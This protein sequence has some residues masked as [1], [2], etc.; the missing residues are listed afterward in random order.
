MVM[1]LGAV[2]IPLSIAVL[3]LVHG[4]GVNA[5]AIALASAMSPIS[6][7]W[8][9]IGVGSPRSILLLDALPTLGFSL[10]SAVAISVLGLPLAAYSTGMLLAAVVPMVLSLWVMRAPLGVLKRYTFRRLCRI[11]A[12]QGSALQSRAISAVYIALPITLVGGAAPASLVVFS[13][14]E[15]L[16]RFV[17]SLLQAFPNAF[18]AWVGSSSPSDLRSR[19]KSVFTAN[20]AFGL[21]SGASYVF[22]APL[23]IKILFAGKIEVPTSVLAL[24]AGVIAIT[25]SSRVTGGIGLVAF[26]RL[27]ALRTSAAIG[28]A[29][30]IPAIFL[31]ASLDGADGA[32]AGEVLAELSVLIVQ[33]VLLAGAWKIVYP[34]PRT[35]RGPSV[36]PGRQRARVR[37]DV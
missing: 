11:A 2:V 7:I 19:L 31:G 32:M 5:L 1:A 29:I 3:L 26:R 8:F 4:I 35:E 22:A 28:A 36:E 16:Q 21:I 20:I 25:S 12:A 30:G 34:A 15:R 9:F 18:Q 24:S 33:F 6:P 13:A 23:G 14:A 37:P 27:P 17:L 10:A